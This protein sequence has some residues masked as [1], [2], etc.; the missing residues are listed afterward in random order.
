MSKN[1]VAI[2][3]LDGWGLG[4]NYDG[5]AINKAKTPNYRKLLENYP[6]TSLEASGLAVGLPSGQ[7]GNSEV[8]HLNIGAGRVIYQELTRISKSIENE[9]FFGKQEFLDAIDNCKTNNSKLHLMGLLSD[10]GVHSHNTHLYAL[11][12]L[13]KKHGLKDVLI[14]CFL[15]GRDVP[16]QSA[17]EYLKQL[18]DKLNEI[19]IGQIA[20][21]SGRYYAMDRDKR[22]DRV[23]KAY[24]A[25]TLG[26]G[27]TAGS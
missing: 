21:I 1:L 13:A 5:N 27:T 26:K 18:E 9:E 2:I 15:D 24:D 23:Q 12:E 8:G 19:G 22:W 3:I 17:K 20:S 4:K 10:G 14:H 16:P 7:M 25:M 6:S 11:V